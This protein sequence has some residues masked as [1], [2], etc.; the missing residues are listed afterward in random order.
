MSFHIGFKWLTIG[1]SGVIFFTA[2]ICKPLSSDQYS[3][4]VF[5]KFRVGSSVWTLTVLAA[6]LVNVEVGAVVRHWSG[7]FLEELVVPSA[8]QEI[9][10]LLRNPEFITVS[11][12][13]CCSV[14]F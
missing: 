5:G 9:P 12:R 13:V 10:R 8:D 11:T 6:V 4:F 14:L 7:L 2:A 3:S 1:S